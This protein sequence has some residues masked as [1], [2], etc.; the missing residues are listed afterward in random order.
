MNKFV[1][2]FLGAM[3][4]SLLLTSCQQGPAETKGKKIDNKVQSIKDKLE[5]K[6]PMQKAGEKIDEVTNN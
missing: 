4:L 3:T 1:K 6:G 5:N 2:L